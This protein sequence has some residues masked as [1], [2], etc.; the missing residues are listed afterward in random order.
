MSMSRW[1]SAL[2]VAPLATLLLTGAASAQEPGTPAAEDL[3]T[4]SRFVLP[5]ECVAEPMA[6][7]DLAAALGGEAQFEGVQITVPL[8]EPADTD[9]AALINDTAREVLACLNAA[10]Y[11]R[12]G[13]ITTAHGA[14]QLLAG[15]VAQSGGDLEARLAEAATARPEEAL[16]RLIA[17]TDTSVLPDGRLAAFVVL[18]EPTNLIRGPETYLMVFT[19]EGDALRLD[20]LFGFSIA[21]APTGTPEA[22]GESS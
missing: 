9:T 7:A 3:E 17:V 18:N 14:Q 12:L 4:P 21:P 6:A 13:S 11:L 8:G 15:L 20:G 2:A 16:I 1:S 19:R 10:D 22:G 5:E